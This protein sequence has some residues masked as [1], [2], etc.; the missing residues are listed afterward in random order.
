MLGSD[1]PPMFNTTLVNEY[2]RAHEELGLDIDQLRAL[3]RAS[4]EASF[5]APATKARLASMAP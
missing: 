2:R 3:A 4:I 1:D 5:A